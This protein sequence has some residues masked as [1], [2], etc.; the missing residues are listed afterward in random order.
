MQKRKWFK[1]QLIVLVRGERG[2]AILYTC[3]GPHGSGME[4]DPSARY[5]DCESMHGYCGPCDGQD[6]S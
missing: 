4:G 5:G 2:E 6:Y 1:P 3:K